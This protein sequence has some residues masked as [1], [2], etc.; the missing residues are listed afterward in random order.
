MHHRH[1]VGGGRR[2]RGARYAAHR[3]HARSA[4]PDAA[5]VRVRVVRYG[6][7]SVGR[8]IAAADRR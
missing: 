5:V 3:A 6:R 7:P 8:R 1:A 4:G 2:G